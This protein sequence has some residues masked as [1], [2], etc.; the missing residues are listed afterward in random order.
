MRTINNIFISVFTIGILASCGGGNTP[1]AKKAK[2]EKLKAQQVELADKIKTLEEE[3]K[4]GGVDLAS[5]ERVKMVA[6]TPVSSQLFEHSIDVQGRVDAD[7]NVT[8]VAKSGGSITKLLVKAGDMVKSGQILAEIDDEIIVK[9]MDDLKKS[10]ELAD[11]IYQKQKTLWDQKIGTE[12]QYLQAKNGKESLEK[13]IAT[14]NEQLDMYR[15]KAPFNG[16][17]DEVL[18]KNGQIVGPGLPCMRIVDMSNLKIKADI[19]ETYSSLVNT[20]NRVK[21]TFPDVNRVLETKV[22]YCS[23]VINLSTR[24]F[25]IE[26]QLPTDNIYKPN[27]VCQIHV[28]DYKNDDALVVPINTV[29]NYNNKSFVF[30]AVKSGTKNSAKKI[31]VKPG[32]S[33]DGR[34]EI[35]GG[36]SKSDM[37]ITTGFQDLNDNEAIKF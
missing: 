27:M 12:M 14:L 19:S 9:Q 25:G 4:T 36:L 20:G 16:T 15:I 37:L 28:I 1:E 31:E 26:I 10:K 17:I 8:I 29:Q 34:V 13:K 32:Q 33:Y 24:T 21:V 23:K 11:E 30:I 6:I 35:L 5:N 18:I 22:S 3:I 7:Q 2:L